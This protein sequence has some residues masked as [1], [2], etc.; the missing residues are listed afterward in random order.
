MTKRLKLYK[1]L[2]T[3]LIGQNFGEDRVCIETN[4]NKMMTREF[5]KECPLGY[6]SVYKKFGLKG[7]N[8][9]DAMAFDW[10]PIYAS[11][12][13]IVEELETDRERGL[14]IGIVSEEK[15]FFHNGEYFAKTR[16]WHLAAFNVKLGERVKTGNLI[17]WSDATGY[18]TGPHLHFELKPV[19][20]D[21]PGTYY[22]V[23]QDNGYY[24]AIDPL[25]YLEPFTA[26][27]MNNFLTRL[28]L[29]IMELTNKVQ[30]FLLKKVA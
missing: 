23:F 10:V 20:Q 14:G 12:D 18:A 17:G 19:L 25:P 27:E 16:Y 7:H 3:F 9:Y 29:Q 15:E 6:M 30:D 22:N 5:K 21:V 26:W 4:G 28:Q 1:P 24:G 11:H 2:K 8:G 13:G